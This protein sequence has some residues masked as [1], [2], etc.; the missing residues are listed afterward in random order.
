[1][2]TFKKSSIISKISFTNFIIAIFYL[3]IF[4][5]PYL[6]YDLGISPEWYFLTIN[7]IWFIVVRISWPDP[8]RFKFFSRDI[9]LFNKLSNLHLFRNLSTLILVLNVLSIVFSLMNVSNASFLFLI[10][11]GIYYSLILWISLKF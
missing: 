8:T 2:I 6:Y 11:F 9:I 4:S 5:R 1:M 7:L 10:I 3:I